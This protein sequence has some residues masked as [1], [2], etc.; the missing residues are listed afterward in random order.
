MNVNK[1]AYVKEAKYLGV[2]ICNDQKDDGY[3]LRHQG[4]FY[5]RTNR[6]IQNFTTV[7]WVLNYIYFMH[8]VVQ[9]NV[10]NYGFTLIS[11]LI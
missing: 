3:I 4:N 1:L 9:L 7:P 10:A 5:A 8:V 6:T 2:I 11:A